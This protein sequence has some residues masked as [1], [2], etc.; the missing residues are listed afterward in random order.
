MKNKFIILSLIMLS[1]F[2]GNRVYASGMELRINKTHINNHQ[3]ESEEYMRNSVFHVFFIGDNSNY[4][5]EKLDKISLSDMKKRYPNYY[6]VDTKNNISANVNLDR[7]GD[8]FIK[9]YN[10]QVTINN[11]IYRPMPVL[12]NITY[13]FYDIMVKNVQVKADDKPT[14]PP[15][16]EGVNPP[17]NRDNRPSD[18]PETRDNF[19]IW[20]PLVLAL[21]LLLMISIKIGKDYEEKR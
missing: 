11:I 19:I 1:L 12:V 21:S 5:L 2:F 14:Q 16:N 15:K 13:P 10:R 4:S 3:K 8:Y 7:K 9:E 6:V 20:E 18:R 17:S